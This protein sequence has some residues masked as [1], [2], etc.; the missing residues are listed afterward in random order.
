VVRVRIQLLVVVE[1]ADEELLGVN[2]LF[3]IH[4][5]RHGNNN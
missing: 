4:C 3:E 2:K 1:G 5:G